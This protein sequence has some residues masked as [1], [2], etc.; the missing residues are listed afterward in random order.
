MTHDSGLRTLAI[1]GTICRRIGDEDGT[2]MA[3]E[4]ALQTLTNT[5]VKL[6]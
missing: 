2:A 4:T 5:T 1:V 3:A 6:L